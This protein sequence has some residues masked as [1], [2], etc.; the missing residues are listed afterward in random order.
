MAEEWAGVPAYA[1]ALERVLGPGAATALIQQLSER[2]NEMQTHGRRLFE[3]WLDLC[4]RD[5]PRSHLA[6]ASD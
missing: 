4:T 2:A 3:R 6:A 5:D 1:D